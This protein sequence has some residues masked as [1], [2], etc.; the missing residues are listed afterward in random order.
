MEVKILLNV[1]SSFW[2]LKERLLSSDEG[3]FFSFQSNWTQTCSVKIQSIHIYISV[4]LYKG[5]IKL[6]QCLRL[7]QHK[8]PSQPVQYLI[9][10]TIA[11]QIRPPPAL[12]A[13]HGAPPPHPSLWSLSSPAG[14]DYSSRVWLDKSGAASGS[15]LLAVSP[16]WLIFFSRFLALDT[17]GTGSLPLDCSDSL[18]R[19]GHAC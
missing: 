2:F 10:M 6:T 15:K 19:K 5:S 7:F 11:H 3:I 17:A 16:S 4:Y 18:W 12:P 14:S 1:E 9:L 13:Q 8:P